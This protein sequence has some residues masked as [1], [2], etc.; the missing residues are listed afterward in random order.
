MEPETPHTWQAPG[1]A[2]PS[3]AVCGLNPEGRTPGHWPASHDPWVSPAWVDQLP[4]ATVS[5]SV[6]NKNVDTGGQMSTGLIR[7][8]TTVPSSSK[9]LI[10]CKEET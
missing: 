2:D 6:V 9:I 10:L 5:F 3:R 7:M 1:A 4:E 8:I